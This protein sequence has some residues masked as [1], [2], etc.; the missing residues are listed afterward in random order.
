MSGA[1]RIKKLD[2]TYAGK[3]SFVVLLLSIPK[4]SKGRRGNDE[5]CVFF[6]AC[7]MVLLGS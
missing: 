4:K 6:S 1:V 2:H 3:H 7:G 5:G